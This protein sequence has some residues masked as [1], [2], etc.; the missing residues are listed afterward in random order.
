[1]ALATAGL[2]ALSG[3]G[4]AAD[5]DDAINLENEG[6]AKSVQSQKRIDTIAD[7]TD[8]M[9]AE[10]RATIDQIASLKVYNAQLQK[11]LDAQQA[12]LDSL[13]TQI[14]NVTVIGREVTPLMLRMVTALEQF[15]EADVP[16]LLTE[17]RERV[18]ALRE[19]MDRADVANSEKYRRIMEA[20]QIENEYGRT[21]ESYQDTLVIGGE[22]RTL[23]FLRIGRIALLYQTLDGKE[24]GT[25]SRAAGDWEQLDSGDYRDSIKKGIRIAQKQAAP[26]LVRIPVAAPEDIQ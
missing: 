5:V 20:Y 1:L 7:Q 26:D 23:D 3:I 17:R 21:I 11:L 6:N 22:E 15:V 16:L 8:A 25:W 14:G 18:A 13:D 12:E 4:H 24:V 2:L 9:A 10:Y 19:L